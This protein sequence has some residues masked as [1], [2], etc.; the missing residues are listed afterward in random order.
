MDTSHSKE[1][2]ILVGVATKLQDM[3]RTMEYLEELAFLVDTAGG[4]VLKKFFQKLEYP[5]PRTYIGSGKLNEVREYIESHKADMAVFDDELTPSQIRNI[6]GELKCRIIDRS[7]LI[8]DIFAKRAQTSN[9][10]TQVE[11]AQYEYLLPRLT[12]R[13]THLE[14]QRGGIGLRGPGEQEIETDR[15]HI[16]AR[17]SLLKDKLEEID[18]QK[19]TQ[20]KH[21]R[22]MIRVALVGYTNVGKS[23]VM[24]LL[25]KSDVFA[26]NK[27]FATLETTVRK[28][29]IDNQPFLLSD[30][31]GFIRKLPHTLI[32]S[33]KSTLDEVREADILIHVADIS[34]PDHEEQINVV[35]QTLTDI[36]ASNKPVIMLFNKI[37]AYRFEVKDAD[38]L[39]PVLRKNLSLEELEKFWMARGENFSLFISATEK[40]HVDTLREA[41]FQQVRKIARQRWPERVPYNEG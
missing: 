40:I 4:V 35:K 29:V 32:D 18:K 6:E 14:K 28:V 24:N 11:L 7:S 10:K 30:T 21:R 31:V 27:L 16:R 19:T 23:T 5:D 13:W 3:E 36:K 22:D 17:I 2:A 12:R 20:R 9:A 39:G 8:L 38:D 33:F 1:T 34:H 41:I 26:E 37:D 25:S 15:R